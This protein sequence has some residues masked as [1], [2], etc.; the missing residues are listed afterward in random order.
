MDAK[1]VGGIGGSDG[2]EGDV[3]PSEPGSDAVGEE[4]VQLDGEAVEAEVNEDSDAVVGSAQDDDEHPSKL[5]DNAAT[6]AG[7]G[8]SN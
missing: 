7:K 5:A 1:F 6:D 4:T 3:Q 2:L 8:K